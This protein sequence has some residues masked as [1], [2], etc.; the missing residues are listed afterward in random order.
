M[1]NLLDDL[2]LPC[3]MISWFYYDSYIVVIDP[4]E[5]MLLDQLLIFFLF[6]LTSALDFHMLAYSDRCIFIW[7][8]E[9]YEEVV[10]LDGMCLFEYYYGKVWSW[11]HLRV[12]GD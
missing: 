5:L 12:I 9:K 6:S 8:M 10:K 2:V 1:F 11:R 4:Y 7:R 3:L